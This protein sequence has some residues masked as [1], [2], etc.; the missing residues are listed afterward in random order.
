MDLMT[1]VKEKTQ[2]EN[3]LGG[4]MKQH[5]FQPG[6]GYKY[7]ILIV[8]VASPLCAGVLGGIE[9]G[10][11]VVNAWNGMSYLFSTEGNY[12]TVDY[13]YEKLFNNSGAAVHVH[14]V[15]ALLSFALGRETNADMDKMEIFRQ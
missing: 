10:F 1:F 14:A 13:I 12:L 4:G 2:I 9:R 3:I 8:S 5:S 11:L 7:D 6:N 15:T